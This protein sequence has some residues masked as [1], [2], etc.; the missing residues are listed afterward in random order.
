MPSRCRARC[1]RILTLWSVDGQRAID[2]AA[3][4]P[5]CLSTGLNAMLAPGVSHA[6]DHGLLF[7]PQAVPYS[8]HEFPYR[9]VAGYREAS[10]T[11]SGTRWVTRPFT[12][13]RHSQLNTIS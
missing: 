8:E 2:A 6:F 12:P 11:A 9:N 7:C 5:P 13:G 4:M 3:W 10:S 1:K